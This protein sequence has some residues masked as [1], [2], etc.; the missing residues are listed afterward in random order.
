MIKDSNYERIYTGSQ[1]SVNYLKNLLAEKGIHVVV[2]D[3]H[4]SSLRAGFGVGYTDQVLL[5]VEK[6]NLVRA[7]RITEKAFD[8]GEIPDNVLDEQ[9]TESRLEQE[10][11]ISKS[12]DRPLIKKDPKQGKRSTINLILNIGLII[13]SMWRLLPLI[14]GETLPI[15]RIALSSFILIFCTISVVNHFRK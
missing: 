2:R 7:K 11:D 5:F 8:E 12:T 9:A 3:D 6:E 15:W 13:Y 10:D 1:I 4:E 14:H